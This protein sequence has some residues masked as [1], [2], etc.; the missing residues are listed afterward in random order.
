MNW[1]PPSLPLQSLSCPTPTVCRTDVETFRRVYADFITNFPS[2]TGFQFLQECRLRDQLLAHSKPGLPV[3]ILALWWGWWWWWW[4]LSSLFST[5]FR[6]GR[7]IKLGLSKYLF[8]NIRLSRRFQFIV[9]YFFGNIVRIGRFPVRAAILIS[10]V[11]KRRRGLQRW[12]K[13]GEKKTVPCPFSRFDTHPRNA[14][15]RRSYGKIGHCE[16]NLGVIKL[17]PCNYCLYIILRISLLWLLLTI[18]F[19]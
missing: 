16:H 14:K 5:S 12:G 18:S 19:L 3:T 10:H 1:I 11:P 6:L 15:S 4:W 9:P 8:V 7:E 2:S 13:G 17:C